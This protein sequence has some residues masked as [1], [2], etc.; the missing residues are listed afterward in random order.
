MGKENN[1]PKKEVVLPPIIP[2][3]LSG[4]SFKPMSIPPPEALLRKTT[5]SQR[6]RSLL[7]N[8]SNPSSD[9]SGAMKRMTSLTVDEQGFLKSLAPHEH[10]MSE[11]HE[12][13]P[14]E[15]QA[16]DKARRR[17]TETIASRKSQLTVS[18]RVFL[19]ELARNSQI[20][21]RDLNTAV[22][23]LKSDPLYKHTGESKTTTS[24]SQDEEDVR[25]EKPPLQNDASF[26]TELWTEYSSS[27]NACTNES[28]REPDPTCAKDTPKEEKKTDVNPFVYFFQ[29]FS[30]R[31]EQEDFKEDDDSFTLDPEQDIQFS[32][33]A[34]SVDDEAARPH[35]LS[36][37]IMDSLRPHLPYSVQQDNFWLKYSLMRDGCSLYAL[38]RGVRS[39]A[40]TILAIETMDGDVFGSFTSSPWRPNGNAYYGSGETFL[41]RLSRSRYTPCKTV[42]EQI[43]LESDLDI[44]GWTG[45][46]RNVQY[47]VDPEAQIILGGGTLDE[48]ISLDE[49]TVTL[50]EK[51]YTAKDAGFALVL[52]NDLSEGTS[53]FSLTFDNP[54]LPTSAKQVFQ[55]QNV[56][57]WTL[58]PVDSLEQAEKL[59]LSRQFVY[60]HGNFIME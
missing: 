1:A 26:R 9:G 58:S 47:L 35:V 11:L 3:R 13:T 54:P 12:E 51:T 27:R 20:S 16:R 6:R 28:E 21:P 8:I 32:I 2:K 38:L 45:K 39:S 37:P 36:P 31:D 56:E 53:G 18:E 50:N 22:D 15:Q 49:A 41:W 23:V 40:R 29:Q 43:K 46:N 44:F 7:R 33:L 57:V 60:D 42:E 25:E 55:I 59:E 30:A 34:T 4:V 17:L 5:S 14:E 19:K 24:L 10:R 52:N 48:G